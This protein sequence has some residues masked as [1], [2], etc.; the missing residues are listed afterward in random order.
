MKRSA[1]AL[2]ILLVAAATALADVPLT[3]NVQ[4]VLTDV[5][6]NPL[7]DDHYNVDFR[8]YDVETGGT[9]LFTND[10]D[11]CWMRLTA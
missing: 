2:L 1:L 6:G 3:M 5:A 11:I 4:G 10:W 7:M 8:F 9:P